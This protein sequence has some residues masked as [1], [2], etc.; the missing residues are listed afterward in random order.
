MA[1][2]QFVLY[3][4]LGFILGTLGAGWGADFKFG[5]IVFILIGALVLFI[6]ARERSVL[7]A[8]R[9]FRKIIIFS[10]L[11]FVTGFFYYHFFLNFRN[12]QINIPLDQPLVFDGIVSTDPRESGDYQILEVSLDSPYR[13]RVSVFL[14]PF[15]KY[16][17]GEKLQITGLAQESR[18]QNDWPV[19][20]DPEVSRLEQHQ[21]F[22]LKQ[23]LLGF[24]NFLVQ[25]FALVLPSDQA[26]LLAG[27]T[28]GERGEF[29]E[30]LKTDMARSGVTHIVALSGY[31]IAILA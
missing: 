10:F 24:E 15:P 25:K 28:F 7:S 29:S 12:Q 13:G 17:Y 8:W 16:E 21:G 22:W 5:A 19:V 14:E 31:N 23:K 3:L 26:A 30:D 2:R 11:C 27:L 4:G 20:F 18:F 1:K 6:R 9:S